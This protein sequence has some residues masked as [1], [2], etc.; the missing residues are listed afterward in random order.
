[1]H[2]KLAI[3]W[4]NPCNRLCLNLIKSPANN[5][6]NLQLLWKDSRNSRL[7]V[8]KTSNSST[9]FLDT[10]STQSGNY[11]L[12]A[13]TDIAVESAPVKWVCISIPSISTQDQ[14]PHICC[15]P[16]INQLPKKEKKKK[17]TKI[18]CTHTI[19]E[20]SKSVAI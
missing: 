8:W 17:N 1:M 14:D 20:M 3:K 2:W 11:L 15:L 18:E 12:L 4:S 9:E 13:C 7:S 10:N 19:R 6:I 5:S 16:I